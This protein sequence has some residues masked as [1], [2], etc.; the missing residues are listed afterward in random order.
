[1]NYQ[2]NAA[3]QQTGIALVRIL[4]G[5]MLI[6]HGW[7]IFD[8]AKMDE[9]AKWE[10]LNG[11]LPGKLM[12]YTGKAAELVSGALLL[13]GLFT[14]VAAVVAALTLLYICF[15]IGQ[16]RFWYEDQHPFVFALLCL[17]FFFTGSGCWSVDSLRAKKNG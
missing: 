12:A 7:E 10:S 5:G 3:W 13:I 17:G 9:Y 16:G 6:Y 8:A 4:T 1:M 14:R 15:F 11:Y 2:S